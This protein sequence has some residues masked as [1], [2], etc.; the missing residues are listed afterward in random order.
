MTSLLLA[1]IL[2]AGLAGCSGKKSVA[3]IQELS[4]PVGAQLETA[5]VERGPVTLSTIY[6]GSVI[7][8]TMEL[9]FDVDGRVKKVNNFIGRDVKT[10]DVILE[11]ESVD[12]AEIEAKEKEL[13]N[14][15][16]ARAHEEK[17]LNWELELAEL[18]LQR[19]AASDAAATEREN[20]AL[21]ISERK[22]AIKQARERFELR[23]N[24]IERKLQDLIVAPERLQLLSP[25][26]GKILYL[27]AF[28]EG[29]TIQAYDTVAVLAD[30]A[31][32]LVRSS[33]VSDY[34]L[35]TATAVTAR[36]AGQDYNLSAHELDWE[37]YMTLVLNEGTPY[38]YY[39]VDG[40]AAGELPDSIAAG[41]YAAVQVTTSESLDTLRIP[42][43]CIYR[44]GKLRYVYVIVENERVR[45][46]VEVGLFNAAWIEITAG[47]EEGERVYI[48]D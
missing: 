4:E 8:E 2:I 11:I 27:P 13:E 39:R 18:E 19:L 25:I 33:F 40:F 9:S 26:D 17:I 45:R 38:T 31:S 22:L 24:Q 10:G 44:D 37:T 15:K 36:I 14:L 1:G 28:A 12:Q 20:Q 21:S 47:L 23:A 43:N 41:L 46:D 3:T 7:P 5:V 6:D 30:E 42:Q 34:Y 48:H 16:A 32:L 35:S 29:D